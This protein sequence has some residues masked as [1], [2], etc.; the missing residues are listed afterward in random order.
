MDADNL[1][2]RLLDFAVRIMDLV[3]ALPQKKTAN[4][5]AKQLI[6]SGT[7]PGANY[8]EARAAESKNDF[9]HKCQIVLK[10]LR[11]SRYWLRIVARKRFIGPQRL[12]PL[13]IEAEELVLIFSKT[14]AT[15]KGK[16]RKLTSG[17]FQS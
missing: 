3:E 11:E 13:L 14:V 8:E 17:S 7:S 6:G 15:A 10:E 1:S 9:I 2:D 16:A 12:S 4:Q 5:C